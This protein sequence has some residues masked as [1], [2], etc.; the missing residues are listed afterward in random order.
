MITFHHY[1]DIIPFVLASLILVVG[2]SKVNSKNPISAL[3]LLT[4]GVYMVA[5]STWFSSWISGNVWGR[6]FSNYIWFFFNTSTMVIFA[7]T[8]IKSGKQE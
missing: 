7:W 1:I 4:T 3:V 5:Q 2:A 6:D 8:L